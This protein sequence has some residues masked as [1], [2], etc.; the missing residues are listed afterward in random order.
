MFE[1]ILNK[2]L[3]ILTIAN[4]SSYRNLYWNLRAKEIDRK[5]GAN[6]GDF[7]TLEKI[8]K[9]NNSQTIL[10]IGCGS[11]RLFKLYKSLNIPEVIAQEIS[12]DAIKICQNRYPELNYVYE[13][14]EIK[15]LTYSEN[16][17][18]LIISNKVLSAVLPSEINE[19]IKK[20][21][22]I[23]KTIYINEPME[24]D[25]IKESNNWFKHNYTSIISKYGFS[26]LE[27][28]NIVKS[29]SY[30]VYIKKVI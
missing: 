14:K 18:D 29:Q 23:S 2:L 8:I 7:D 16:Y 13:L 17:F 6:T 26:I 1:K 5:W 10:D 27:E 28:G 9:N 12:V 3:S 19:V 15:N 20:L 4:N 24:D 11:G 21:A 25:P 30:K 22:F